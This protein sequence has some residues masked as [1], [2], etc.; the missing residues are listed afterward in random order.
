MALPVFSNGDCCSCSSASSTSTSLSTPPPPSTTHGSAT[1]LFRIDMHTHIMPPSL[2][3][4][5]SLAPASSDYQ[6]P[7]FK[8]IND[9]TSAGIDMYV[10]PSFFR[11]VQPNCYD[12]TVRLREMDTAGVDVQVLST[13]P[14]L[15]CYDAPVKPAIHLAESLND[16]IAQICTAHPTRFVGL[17]TLP[18]QD[19]PSSITE[20]RRCMTTL[21]LR[22]IQIGS[23]VSA[24]K[25]LDHPDFEPLWAE[26]EK[27]HCPV[28]IH[29]LGYALPK[30][31]PDR[32]SKYWASWLVGMPSETALAVHAL[33]ASGVLV[34]HPKLRVCFAH[35]GGAFPA[36][37][38]RI[39]HGYE[40][41][42]DLV[43]RDA[44][45]VRPTE[46][47]RGAQVWIDS[48]VH[49]A[50]L[51][52]YVVKKMGGTGR[53]VMGSD[54][55][56]PLGEVPVAGEMLVGDEVG[57][58]MRLEERAGVL[59]GNAIRFLGLGGE[60]EEQVAERLRE[61]QGKGREGGLWTWG[62]E[63]GFDGKEGNGRVE[64]VD[65]DW[66]SVSGSL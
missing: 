4:L 8:P 2:P 40:C 47:V 30:E 64:V 16:H 37:L 24:T 6:W 28:F 57:A 7:S 21:G 45:G 23:S 46:H 66:D 53:I 60:F 65:G 29:P 13:V 26:C 20:L 42:P 10:G 55:P 5:S 18:L 12:P 32:W 39:R 49:D 3:D 22:G 63:T 25:M 19:I 50:D 61:A 1:G 44:M 41:R 54:Y 31:N 43:A 36:L 56:F 17:G 9:P 15:F 51:L 34:R 33:T 27:L 59:G 52:E 14:I 62:L 58:F 11:R 48:L 38:G 35:G